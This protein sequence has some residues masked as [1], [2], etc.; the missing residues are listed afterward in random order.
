MRDT[1]TM[2]T[3]AHAREP[4]GAIPVIAA[5]SFVIAPAAAAAH[6]PGDGPGFGLALSQ[7]RGQL[8]F[9]YR[10]ARIQLLGTIV[11]DRPRDGFPLA[12]S[13]TAQTARDPYEGPVRVALI[14]L[15][16][17]GPSV[18]AQNA[19]GRYEA[20]LP[21]AAGTVGVKITLLTARG[22]SLTVP[23]E[24]SDRLPPWVPWAT[25]GLGAVGTGALLLRNRRVFRSDELRPAR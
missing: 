4:R 18:V 12:L 17:E 13:F 8:G 19:G 6:H 21:V 1:H 15:S 2:S 9:H 7:S 3:M 11:P 24:P 23:V 5:L 14:T 22:A 16:G 10:D 20:G 25:L